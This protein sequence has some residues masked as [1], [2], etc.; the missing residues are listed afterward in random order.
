[1]IEAK[2][3]PD[4]EKYIT[5]LD[6]MKLD[7][8]FLPYFIQKHLGDK[9]LAELQS[10][11]EEGVKPIP[12]DASDREKYEI[13]YNNWIWR[14]K[15]IFGLV[16]E[17]LGDDGIEQLKRDVADALKKKNAGSALFLLRAIRAISKG[18]AFKM[19]AKQIAYQ[20]Q[21]LTPYSV[22]ELNRHRLVLDIPRCKILDFPD[23]GDICLV[24]CQGIYPIWLAEQLSLEMKTDRHGNKCTVTFTPL[25]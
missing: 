7:E 23:S 13:A 24:G 3:M 4:S 5:I 6:N 14:D 25:S 10:L 9:A 20:L 22:S 17:R 19:T 21:W 1:M 16:R 11:F 15:S 18:T 8:T 12:L 2:Q